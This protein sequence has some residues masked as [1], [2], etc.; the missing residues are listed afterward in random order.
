MSQIRQQILT[1][2]SPNEAY[3]EIERL[4]KLYL[5]KFKRKITVDL[6]FSSEG[7]KPRPIYGIT[8]YYENNPEQN[9]ELEW[10]KNNISQ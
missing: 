4:E 10:L 6:Y 1:S 5:E 9:L 2:S 7:D 8:V 3:S